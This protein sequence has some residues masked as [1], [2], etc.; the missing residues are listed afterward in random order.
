MRGSASSDEKL[1]QFA[2]DTQTQAT[3]ATGAL[4][5]TLLLGVDF[6]RTRND[7]DVQFGS[8][9]SLNAVAPQYGD[10][11]VTPYGSLSAPQ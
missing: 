8:A 11:S 4:D 1:N 6:Q 7:I 3:F 10:E 2:V 9:R 5:H